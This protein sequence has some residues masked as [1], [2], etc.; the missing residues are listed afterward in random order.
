MTKFATIEDM[1]RQ[2]HNESDSIAAVR[3]NGEWLSVERIL[4]ADF[5]SRY[6]YRWGKNEVPRQVA[7]S[8]LTSGT[9]HS[10]SVQCPHC[11][12]GFDRTA[13]MQHIREKH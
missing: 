9:L 8:V 1:E 7:E 6:E 10:S 2:A 4:R 12:F 5:S 11:R 13:I 3:I